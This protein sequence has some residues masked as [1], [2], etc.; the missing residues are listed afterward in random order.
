MSSPAAMRTLVAAARSIYR[1]RNVSMFNEPGRAGPGPQQCLRC[2]AR[3][4]RLMKFCPQCGA[5]QSSESR[6]ADASELATH[7]LRPQFY[8]FGSVVVFALAITAYGILHRTEPET[9]HVVNEVGGAVLMSP[10]ASAPPQ[11]PAQQEALTPP[12][13]SLP[14]DAS[15]PQE[16]LAPPGASVPQ[17]VAVPATLTPPTVVVDAPPS[18]PLAASPSTTHRE[19]HANTAQ[20][21]AATQRRLSAERAALARRADANMRADVARNIAIARASLDKNDL[22]QARRAVMNVLAEQPGNGA[23]LQMQHELVSREQERDAMLGYARLCMRQAQW[24]CAWHNAGRALTIDAS[25]SEARELISRA[26][27]EHSAGGTRSF[28]PSLPGASN[29]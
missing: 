3:I 2:G 7:H 25:S 29:E 22:S 12:Q 8:A 9:P 26:M 14:Q 5:N 18:Q 16:A 21:Y 11:A 6:A 23:A 15:A 1:S 17:V 13:A 4:N 27:V 24:V 20:R 19:T 10:Q 28:D